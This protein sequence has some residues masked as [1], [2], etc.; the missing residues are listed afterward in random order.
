MI[1]LFIM[2]VYLN[3]I[4]S[5]FSP[6]PTKTKVFYYMKNLDR[7]LYRT[8]LWLLWNDQIDVDI[9][10]NEISVCG[11]SNRSLDTHQTMFFG[12]LKNRFAVQIFTVPWIIDIG[13]DPAYIFASSETPFSKTKTSHV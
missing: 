13:S 11:S 12:S 3:I 10:M 8:V 5:I 6:S 1:S 4:L 7:F 9:G 2:R